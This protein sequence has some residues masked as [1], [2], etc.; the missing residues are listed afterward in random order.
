MFSS[1]AKMKV[2]DSMIILSALELYNYF[3]DMLVRMFLSICGKYSQKYC[4]FLQYQ[5]SFLIPPGALTSHH[6]FCSFKS[7]AKHL[8]PKSQ[9]SCCLHLFFFPFSMK[10]RQTDGLLKVL[11]AHCGE[12]LA[13]CFH[14]MCWLDK[15][16]AIHG[17]AVCYAILLSCCQRGSHEKQSTW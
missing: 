9:V 6:C 17:S 3:C 8:F 2:A 5:I 11:S 14:G 4:L 15:D 13:L 12:R 10:Q 7:A 16:C 1:K